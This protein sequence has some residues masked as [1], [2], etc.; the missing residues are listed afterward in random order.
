MQC[1]VHNDVNICLKRTFLLKCWK[2]V[3]ARLSECV[4]IVS[5]LTAVCY[6]IVE[7]S[8][9]LWFYHVCYSCTF[10]NKKVS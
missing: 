9:S 7:F 10:S 3:A 4:I 6:V 1:S 5:K 8:I 2:F